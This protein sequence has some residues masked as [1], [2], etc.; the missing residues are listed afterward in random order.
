MRSILTE[1]EETFAADTLNFQ[2]FNFPGR[3]NQLI[4]KHIFVA[5]EV[6]LNSNSVIV[7]FQYVNNCV[8]SSRVQSENYFNPP[9]LFSFHSSTEYGKFIAKKLHACHETFSFQIYQN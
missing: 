3:R 7:L 1:S 9:P 8:V 4:E 6:L 5:H 2:V